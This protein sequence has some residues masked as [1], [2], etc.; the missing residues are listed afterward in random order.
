MR[1]S[2]LM[3]TIAV[4]AA[5]ACGHAQAQ[6]FALFAPPAQDEIAPQAVEPAPAEPSENEDAQMDPR[7]QRQIVDYRGK[8]APGT[9][10]VDTPHTY[11]YYVLGDG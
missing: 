6:S 8:E 10:I 9:I 3:A 7:L 4:G 1:Q 11:L 5:L 2:M